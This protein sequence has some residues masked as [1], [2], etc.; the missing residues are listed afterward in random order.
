VKGWPAVFLDRDGTLI[1]ERDYLADPEGVQFVPG[2][3]EALARLRAAGMPY[4]IVTN[5]SGIARGLYTLDDYH[6]VAARVLELLE[7][8][9][10]PP[11]DVRFC[12][13]HPEF[14]G[15]CECRKPATGM[16]RAAA[17]EHGLDPT[18]S[19][20]V[21]DKVTDVLPARELGGVGVLVRTGFGIESE[22]EIGDGAVVVDDV[23]GAI[24]LVLGSVDPGMG[25]G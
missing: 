18:R 21:G 22:A 23:S 6:R 4:V 3:L 25:P 14:T 1:R 13:H 5:Q 7:E 10:V 12:P 24:E 9:G 11:L 17:T 16:Y 20:Y 15:P 8:A 2:A 19:F